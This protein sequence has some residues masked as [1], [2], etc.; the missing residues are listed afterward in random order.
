M[1][2]ILGGLPG[3]GKTTLARGLAQRLAAVHVRIDSIEQAL[4]S[5]PALARGV[6]EEGYLAAYAVAE[7]NLRLGHTVI[8]DSVNPIAITR[9]A[10]RGVAAR[11]GVH[12]LEVEVVCSDSVEH[13]RRVETRASD[14]AGLALPR[15]EDVTARQYERWTPACVIDTAARSAE[16][17]IAELSARI[18][19]AR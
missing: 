13:R 12:A 15:W 9:E 6:R 18:A 7:D 10:W 11:A 17:A 8:A 16:E 4:R 5:A 19:S 3:A 2:V 1:L 14:I